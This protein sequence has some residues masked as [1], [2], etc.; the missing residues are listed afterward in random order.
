MRRAA[1]AIPVVAALGACDYERPQPYSPPPAPDIAAPAPDVTA[2]DVTAP[3]PDVTPPGPDVAWTPPSTT[4]ATPG[5]A[6]AHPLEPP[7]PL[8]PAPT[9]G[10]RRMDVTQLDLAFSDVLGGITW[11]A[12]VNGREV[13]QFQALSE[14]LGMPDFLDTTFEDL[15]ATSLFAKFLA[16]ASRKAC[17]DRVAADLAAPGSAILFGALSPNDTPDTA[18]DATTAQLSSLLLRFHGKA[19]APDSAELGEWRWL[20]AASYQHTESM[21]TAWQAVCVALLSHPDFYTY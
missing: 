1:L 17:A 2:P 21:A 12:T 4:P 15:A 7:A 9:R 5:E 14:T 18:P 10:R 11:T 3:A 20:L 19:F 8:P 13:N 16:D 6:E